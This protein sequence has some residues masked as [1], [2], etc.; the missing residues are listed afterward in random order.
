MKLARIGLLALGLL[1][2]GPAALVYAQEPPPDPNAISDSLTI[3]DPVGAIFATVSATEAEEEAQGGVFKWIPISG[4]V[5]LSKFTFPI[6]LTEGVDAQGQPII[7]D[8]FGITDP[9]FPGVGD[10]F[11][12]FASDTETPISNGILAGTNPSFLDEGDGIVD[13]TQFLDPTLVAQGYRAEFRSD[14]VPEPATFSLMALGMLA[15]ASCRRRQRP[16]GRGAC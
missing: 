3:Y 5:D 16:A 15:L 14:P 7:S 8:V 11:L 10:Y 12:G 4:I 2:F 13:A 1:G 9:D 6:V